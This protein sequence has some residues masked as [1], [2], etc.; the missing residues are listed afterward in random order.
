[1]STLRLVGKEKGARSGSLSV[2]PEETHLKLMHLMKF[3][4]YRHPSHNLGPAHADSIKI[5]S[6][7]LA[8]AYIRHAK[9]RNGRRSSVE[10]LT[11]CDQHSPYPRSCPAKTPACRTSTTRVSLQTYS[12]IYRCTQPVQR[13]PRGRFPSPSWEQTLKD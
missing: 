10:A 6:F 12:N 9:R 7:R 4:F 3:D 13:H 2:R 8:D 1:M 11:S 5:N